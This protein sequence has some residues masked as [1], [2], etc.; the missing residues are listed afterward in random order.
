MRL[1]DI[2]RLAFDLDPVSP[3]WERR[4]PS[5]QGPWAQFAIWGAE[6]NF[7][8]NW[9]PAIRSVNEG[10]YV[11]LAPIADWFLRCARY[12]AYEESSRAFPTDVDLTCQL[13]KENRLNR[14]KA[15]SR[16]RPELSKPLFLDL[17]VGELLLPRHGPQ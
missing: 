3:S 7:C 8:R 1:G 2:R 10:V 4:T 12:I 14:L 6:Q 11:P 5:D 9:F 16:K 13:H 15:P 17:T